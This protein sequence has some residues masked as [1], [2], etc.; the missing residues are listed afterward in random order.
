MGAI[1]RVNCALKTLNSV[2]GVCVIVPFL[3]DRGNRIGEV[4][5]TSSANP[6]FTSLL[7]HINKRG[8]GCI[9]AV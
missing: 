3:G 5:L 6:R 9:E 4:L 1:D 8:A 2:P 7:L